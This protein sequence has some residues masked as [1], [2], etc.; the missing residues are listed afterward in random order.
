MVMSFASSPFVITLYEPAKFH[1]KR[2]HGSARTA[3]FGGKRRRYKLT[4]II[5]RY[6]VGDLVPL[7]I[8]TDYRGY[9]CDIIIKPGSYAEMPTEWQ[10]HTFKHKSPF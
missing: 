3:I 5:I 6:Q 10:K 7:K 2:L 4:I 8:K 1:E 9:A